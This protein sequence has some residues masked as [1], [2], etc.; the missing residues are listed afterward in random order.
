MVMK[1]T[2][3]I[4]EQ[5]DGPLRYTVTSETQLGLVYMVDLAPD[6]YNHPVCTCK[7]FRCRHAPNIALGKDWKQGHYCKHIEAV[8]EHL[9]WMLIDTMIDMERNK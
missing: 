5:F 9:A 2:R 1:S 6:D 7:D 8:V 3:L 4:V